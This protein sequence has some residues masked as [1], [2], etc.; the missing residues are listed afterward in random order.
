MLTEFEKMIA[1]QYYDPRDQDLVRRRRDAQR[2]CQRYNQMEPHERISRQ[3]LL[4]DLLGSG[5]KTAQIEAPF[6]CDYG[7]NIFLGKHCFINLNCVFLDACPITLGDNCLLGP[8]AQLYASTHPL[9]AELRRQHQLGQPIRLGNDVWLGGGVILCPGVTI[10]DRA[11]IGAGSVV[12]RDVPAD[13]VA[14]G[15]PC[16]I[17]RSAP[18]SAE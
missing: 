7:S 16:R 14:A 4:R 15:N 10:G 17:L 9:D 12:T 2:L 11:V 18:L 3:K 1:G 6:Y 5:A 13:V 8:G